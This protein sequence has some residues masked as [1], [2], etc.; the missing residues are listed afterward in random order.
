MDMHGSCGSMDI[1]MVEGPMAMV[2]RD[3]RMMGEEK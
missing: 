3:R 2:C 1:D